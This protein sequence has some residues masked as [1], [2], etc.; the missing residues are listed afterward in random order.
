VVEKDA[1]VRT[2]SN[3]VCEQVKA[4]TS[5]QIKNACDLFWVRLM[6]VGGRIQAGFSFCVNKRLCTQHLDT[7]LR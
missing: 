3:L 7:I 6:Q 1:G 2:S 4:L 5:Q